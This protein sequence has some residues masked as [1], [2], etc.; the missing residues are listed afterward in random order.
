MDPWSIIDLYFKDRH[1]QQLVRHQIESYNGF[2]RDQIPQTIEMFNPTIIRSDHFYNPELKKYSLEAN[3][4]FTNFQLYRPQIIENNGAIKIMYPQEARL[5]GFTYAGNT[6]VDLH[7][8]YSH[9]PFHILFF[10][11][12]L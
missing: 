8:Q 6:T 2:I 11:F 9:W 3:I 1:L 7:I 10:L 4:K 5:R 12:L